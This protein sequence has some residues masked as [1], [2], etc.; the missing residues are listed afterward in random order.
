MIQEKLFNNFLILDGAYGTEFQKLEFNEAL[1]EGSDGCWELLNLTAPELIQGVHE[2]YLKAGADIIKANSFGALPWVLDEFERG[3][4]TYEINL[5]AAKIAKASAAKFENRYVCASLG[6]GTKLPSLGH[7]TYEEMEAGYYLAATAHIEGGSDLFLLETCQ[8]PLQIKAAILGIQRALQE[9]NTDIPIMVSVTIETMGTMLV[10]TPINVIAKTLEPFNLF[11]IGINCGLGPK[12]VRNFLEELSASTTKAISVHTNAGLPLNEGGCT[13]YPMGAEEFAAFE[14]TFADIPGVAIVGGCC[15]TTPEHIATLKASL[16]DKTPKK[17]LGKV[18]ASL[19]SLFQ[20]SALLQDPSPLLV[21]ERTNATGSKAFRELLLKEDFEGIL[22]VAQGQ[23]ATGAHALDISVGFAGRDEESDLKKSVALFNNKIAIPLMIDSTQPKALESALKRVGGKPIINSAN[24][25]DGIEKFDEIAGLAKKYGAALV[26]LTIDEKGMAKTKAEKVNI[27]KRMIERAVNVIGLDPQDLVFDTLTF[28]LGSGDA[29]FLTAGMETI[30]A[31]RELHDAF[32]ECGYIL[33]LSNISFG[34]DKEARKYLNSVFLHHCIEAGLSAAIL[35]VAHIIPYANISKEDREVCEKLLFNHEKQIDRLY[36]F[37]NHFEGKDTT[38]IASNDAHLSTEEQ[39]VHLLKTGQKE[40]M[41][42]LLTTAKDELD[43][44]NIINKHLM[45]GMAEIGEMFGKGE[46]QLPFVLQSAE[47]M[48]ASVDYLNDFLPK[49]TKKTHTTIVLGTVKGD[50]HD[51]GKNLV[52]IILTNNGFKV[53]N[54]GIKADIEE[55]IAKAKEY[56]ADALGMSGLLVKSTKIMSDNIKEL[57]NRGLNLPVLLGGAALNRKFVDEY[58]RPFY[59]SDVHY[60]RDAFD[61]LRAMQMIEKGERLTPSQ[62]RETEQPLPEIAWEH[63]TDKAKDLGASKPLTASSYGKQEL[64]LDDLETAFAWLNLEHIFRKKWGFFKKGMSKAEFEAIKE[65]EVLPQYEA[66]KKSFLEGLFEPV[67]LYG[68]YPCRK[69]GNSIVLAD[70][71]KQHTITFPRQQ[72]EP[73]LCLSD[74]FRKDSDVIGVSLVSSGMKLKAHTRALYDAG[75][76]HEYFL[77]HMLSIELAEALADIVHK[78][79]R[80]DLGLTEGIEKADLGD[81]KKLGFTGQ[82][83]SFGYPACP[84]M[85]PN[86]IIFELLEPERFGIT[87]TESF[88]IDPEASTSA[89]IT[90]SPH[91]KYFTV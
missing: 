88:Q 1:W 36:A 35:N 79:F 28:T 53:I 43:P 33:G 76:Y 12:E 27:A 13:V 10:G 25:E 77:T 63:H 34:L 86:K 72:K 37:I 41:L 62:S 23:V 38:E 80:I 75:R 31:I 67:A 3:S 85:E 39:I 2:S 54:I 21:A 26:C 24:L 29:E 40:K 91:A 64:V 71:D 73:H 48:K 57:E 84:D 82:R 74:Y 55:F 5:V 83:Y 7:I 6:P 56:N 58:C 22:S 32:P 4:Q 47:V 18:K 9:T 69:E 46:M 50:V 15:G 52:D 14:S 59:Q 51:V 87:L 19:T 90:A 49:T 30:E 45:D 78:R 66:L 61:G 42:T 17:G 81:V 11:S 44:S 70:G 65:K 20:E 16:Q 8:D 60:C 89:I 68:Y